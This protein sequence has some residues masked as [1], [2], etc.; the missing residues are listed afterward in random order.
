MFFMD[1]KLMKL[2][3][4]SGVFIDP[5][6]DLELLAFPANLMYSKIIQE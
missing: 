5:A 6:L 1:E 4:T 2:F 3:S